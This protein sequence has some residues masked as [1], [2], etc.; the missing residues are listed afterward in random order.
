MTD[1]LSIPSLLA[2][3]DRSQIDDGIYQ[4]CLEAEQLCQHGDA[5]QAIYLARTAAQVAVSAGQPLAIGF[6]FLY[7]AYVRESSQIESERRLAAR[8]CDTAIKWLKRDDHHCALA[9]LIK[10]RILVN[11]GRWTAAI[12]PYQHALRLLLRLAKRC[13]RQNR[14]DKPYWEL[15][16]A[17]AKQVQ[18]LQLESPRDD[19]YEQRKTQHAPASPPGQ[20]FTIPMRVSWSEGQPV[21][22]ALIPSPRGVAPDYVEVTRVWVGGKP[23]AIQ[24]LDAETNAPSSFKL[25]PGQPYVAVRVKSDNGTRD[26]IDCFVLVRRT[27]RPDQSPQYIVVVD[28]ISQRAWIDDAE[29]NATS[30]RVTGLDRQW[31]IRDGSQSPVYDESDL[32]IVG[33]VEAL[34]LPAPQDTAND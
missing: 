34:L 28:P 24:T 25:Q 31:Q 6:T 32:H 17:V 10:A 7:L 21:G 27:D 2:R 3:F 23:Y 9:E 8:D 14:P 1:L 16:S 18:R 19:R 22:I 15:Y 4:R 26:E 11:T 13:Q 33:V 29:S 5:P 30:V 12:A 20:P